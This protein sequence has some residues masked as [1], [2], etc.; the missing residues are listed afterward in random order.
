MVYKD[1]KMAPHCCPCDEAPLISAGSFGAIS[2]EPSYVKAK[3][4]VDACKPPARLNSSM[5]WMRIPEGQRVAQKIIEDTRLLEGAVQLREEYMMAEILQR[6]KYTVTAWD[7]VENKTVEK[8]T[9]DFKRLDHLSNGCFEWGNKDSCTVL[10][11][12]RKCAREV[13]CE[14]NAVIDTWLMGWRAHDAF[15]SNP[16]VLDAMKCNANQPS[17]LFDMDL[18]FTPRNYFGSTT[19]EGRVGQM[20]IWCSSDFW[21]CNGEKKYFIDPDAVIGLSLN[22][23]A[24]VGMGA[25][26][27]YGAI[28][29]HDVLE[30]M[31]RH[32]E[33]WKTID[34]SKRYEKIESAPMPI[35]TNANG[36]VYKTVKLANTGGGENVK[37]IAQKGGA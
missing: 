8:G 11:D 26:R 30:P 19:Y 35:L 5:P 33:S 20:D 7:Q 9:V 12:M 31:E 32:L 37:K 17:R 14:S 23:A 25:T 15:M 36:T 18:D 3:T 10:A 2:A 29:I 13:A 4:V 6:G 34:P 27:L 28:K 21:N 1:H 22:Q 16:E 24:D